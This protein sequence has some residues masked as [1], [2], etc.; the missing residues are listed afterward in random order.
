M[1]QGKRTF[2]CVGRRVSATKNFV[3]EFNPCANVVGQSHS[4][5]RF[6]LQST[7]NS[8]QKCVKSA[9]VRNNA[10]EQE[11]SSALTK[12]QHAR[13]DFASAPDLSGATSAQKNC[14]PSIDKEEKEDPTRISNKESDKPD[15]SAVAD[16]DYE[17]RK[18]KTAWQALRNGKTWMKS[19]DAIGSAGTRKLYDA[20]EKMTRNMDK[21]QRNYADPRAN[22]YLHKSATNILK[23]T[24]SDKRPN[25]EEEARIIR[26]LIFPERRTGIKSDVDNRGGNQDA[27]SS[28]VTF[29]DGTRR[30]NKSLQNMKPS[31]SEVTDII[32]SL[33]IGP[34]GLF[35]DLDARSTSVTDSHTSRK[36]RSSASNI[37][38]ETSVDEEAGKIRDARSTKSVD[39]KSSVMSASTSHDNVFVQMGVNALNGSVSRERLSQILRSKYLKK[40][41]SL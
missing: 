2:V 15:E 36:D 24:A 1:K 29:E 27:N 16:V 12:L 3:Y 21:V 13:V 41:L 20:L 22:S 39:L 10:R 31:T 26:G 33:N 34:L 5:T 14:L 18:V 25:L 11:S 38:R 6:R 7:N 28:K 40:D 30:D 4:L 17:V 8:R 35:E 37:A 9:L 19:R 32:A 23:K